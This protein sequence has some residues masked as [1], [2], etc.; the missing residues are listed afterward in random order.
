MFSTYLENF[1]PFSSNLKLSSVTSFS[2][3]A[4]KICVWERVRL[5]ETV[6]LF[7]GSR[8]EIHISRHG[9]TFPDVDEDYKRNARPVLERA[10]SDTATHDCTEL[11]EIKLLMSGESNQNGSAPDQLTRGDVMEEDKERNRGTCCEGLRNWSIIKLI[12]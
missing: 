5:L 12:R 4:S 6:M 9:I 1:L 3:E 2:F 11:V 8:K 10:L 7:P